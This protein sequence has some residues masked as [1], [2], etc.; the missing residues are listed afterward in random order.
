MELDLATQSND[1]I[2]SPANTKNYSCNFCEEKFDKK[3][4]LKDHFI[5]MH[6]DKNDFECSLCKQRYFLI[7]DLTSHFKRQHETQ[8]QIGE[9]ACDMC[10]KVF[11]RHVYLWRHKVRVHENVR[12]FQ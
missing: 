1:T 6:N 5:K 7:E 9:F 2:Y 4:A 10:E 3:L 12:N 11:S 8:V